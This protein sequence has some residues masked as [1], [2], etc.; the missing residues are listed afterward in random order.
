MVRENPVLYDEEY[1]ASIPDA[2]LR[3]Q[4][5]E[6]WDRIRADICWQETCIIEDVWI[7]LLDQYARKVPGLTDAMMEAMRWTDPLI[8]K[9]K[10]PIDSRP[11]SQLNPMSSALDKDYYHDVPL[12]EDVLEP[13]QNIG[14]TAQSL[15]YNYVVI[16][17][18]VGHV[19]PNSHQTIQPNTHTASSFSRRKSP[20]PRPT[21][22]I[23]VS[24]P[25]SPKRKN[26]RMP[27]QHTQEPNQLHDP[28]KEGAP[29]GYSTR[30]DVLVEVE[31]SSSYQTSNTKM[32]KIVTTQRNSAPQGVAQRKLM[33]QPVSVSGCHGGVSASLQA[34]QSCQKCSAMCFFSHIVLLLFD[35]TIQC[36][37]KLLN[38]PE[39]WNHFE[40]DNEVVVE[41]EIEQQPISTGHDLTIQYDEDLAFQQHINSV[42]NRLQDDD[43]ALLKF[44]MQ[45]IILDAR[46]G[47]GT[48]KQ[49]CHGEIVLTGVGSSHQALSSHQSHSVHVDNDHGI[50]EPL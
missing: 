49:V 50:E 1:Q 18:S 26:H 2:Q 15:K 28:K 33:Q 24:Y 30:S 21:E 9:K 8:H 44:N 39:L 17:P 36:P 6:T 43:K 20:S 16:Q 37:I 42:L 32:Y 27:N 34:A 46:F 48:A 19:R 35:M 3:I 4:R 10:F 23:V 47:E 12:T 40:D 14:N 7:D 5:R 25:L 29:M 31:P 22:A 13:E 41:E 45:R 38:P 11:P